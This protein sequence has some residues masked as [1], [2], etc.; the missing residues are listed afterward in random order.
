MSL[1]RPTYQ[2]RLIA[3]N[4]GGLKLHASV[5]MSG[6]QVGTV[7]KVLLAPDGKS[8]TITLT[9]YKEYRIYRDAEFRIQQ[10]GFLGDQ[11]IAVRPTKNEGEWFHGGELAETEEPFDLQEVARSASGFI[12]R[13][14][15]TARRL[16]AAIDDIRR[17][18]LNE[19]T[20]SNLAVTIGTMRQ[21]SERAVVMVDDINRIFATNGPAIQVAAS[22]LVAFSEDMALFADRLNT[23]LQTNAEEFSIA[24]KNVQKSTET[25]DSILKDVH[26]GKGTAGTLLHNEQVAADV[27][28]IVNNLS[29]STSNLNRLGFWRWMWH[30][31][32]PPRT[33]APSRPPAQTKP[34][35]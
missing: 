20:L 34:R 12:R 21:A 35:Y 30:R 25:I 3:P 28:A 17:L 23:V 5:L 29:L 7:S 2:I 15:D 14:D 33:N 22:N 32:T 27:T 18:V 13:I 31:E 9:I 11:Y 6:V 8:V 26:A 16:N 10:A 19:V 24:V 4:V 1:F